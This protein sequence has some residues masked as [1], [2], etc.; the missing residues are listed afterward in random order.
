MLGKGN[1]SV[2]RAVKFME[3]IYYNGNII[4]MEEPD[5][6]SAIKN[7]PEA[8]LVKNGTIKQVGMLK[9]LV[10]AAGRRAKYYNL[11][12]HCLMPAFIDA[13][14]HFVMSAQ[15]SM[16]A[17]LSC[18]KSFGDI[19]ETLAQYI[20]KN[21]IREKHAVIGFG[22]D[23]NFLD[24]QRHPDKNVLDKVSK[25]IPILIL[26]ISGHLG[27]ANSAA[28]KMGKI[29]PET[30]DPSGG[31]IGRLGDGKEPSGYLEE[32]ALMI[33]QK[34]IA[35][36][37]KRN[38]RHIMKD[39]QTIYLRHGITTVQDGATNMQG[40][41]L[42]R[43]LSMLRLLK[44]DVVAY[45]LM[46][47]GGCGIVHKYGDAYKNYHNHLKIGGYKLVLD[48]SPQ[49]KTAWM[50]QP[51]ENSE[52]YKG[53]QW[54]SDKEV[55]KNIRIAIKEGKQ[56]LAHC[57]GD[58][59]SEQYLNAY[60]RAVAVTKKGKKI[61]PVMIHCQT[62]RNDQI[63]RMAKLGM[64]ASVFIG[65]VWYWG[66]VHI[67]NFGIERGKRISP[68]SDMIRRDVMVNF[69]QDTPVTKPD[70]LHSVWCAVNRISRSGKVIGEE[71]KIPVYDALK[72]ITVNAAYQYFEEKEKGSIQ[73][74]KRADFV[75][76]DRS[77]LEV[78]RMEIKDIMIVKTIKNGK[79]LYDAYSA[80]SF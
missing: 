56:I 74:G 23:H 68:V 40:F 67:R 76:L 37:V 42:L 24:E 35:G 13:H 18:C 55:E 25:T 79:V 53:Y 60:E 8:I 22:Y 66:D 64:I 47:A 15:M 5:A 44:L 71:Q 59:A 73:K 16:C 2:D 4:T 58:A 21:K 54:L 32:S 19:I 41:K 34:A 6:E 62:V 65:H 72:A 29:N 10:A 31:H 70:M 20:K 17:D 52:G 46:T 48:G 57:N 1:I 77:P 75:V 49:G 78:D 39:A 51:Y 12:G 50:S 7:A 11:E 43:I 69:H 28:L 14:S 80:H 26:H 33:L 3:E 9:E 61:R 45:P 27:C 30:L 63:D 36:K 38:A